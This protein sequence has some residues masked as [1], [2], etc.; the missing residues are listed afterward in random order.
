MTALASLRG[1]SKSFGGISAVD[2]VSF[3]IAAGEVVALVGHNG[4]GK[5]TL[6]E[7]LSGVEH[8]DAGEIRVDGFPVRLSSPRDAVAAGIA[9]LHQDLALADHLDVVANVFLGRESLRRGLLDET[10]MGREARTLIDRLQPGF[11]AY[12]TPVRA[13]SGGQRQL[14]AMARAL[15]LEARLLLMDE[16]TA[17][18][19]PGESARVGDW[20]RR[21]TADG[22]GI[23]L[24]SH[25][26]A[27][28]LEMADRVVVMR[29]GRCVADQPSGRL[30]RE[31]LEDW[32]LGRR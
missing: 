21:L 22:V 19:G 2:D 25:D 4:A 18:L 26:L 20:V 30:D 15:R 12:G 13:L 10:A 6:V 31:S 14:V 17:A 27:R 23:L 24:V 16:P 8:P 1:V 28:V 32:I 3:D 7:L 11:D 9:T 5:T 29:A